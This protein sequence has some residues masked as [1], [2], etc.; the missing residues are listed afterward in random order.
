MMFKSTACVADSCIFFLGSLFRMFWSVAV[1][2]GNARAPAPA[3]PAFPFRAALCI[4]R[5]PMDP[6]FAKRRSCKEEEGGT[7]Q[8]SQWTGSVPLMTKQDA[9]N[10]SNS[11]R[12]SVPLS[13]QPAL[14]ILMQCG[15]R[16]LTFSL[17]SLFP[18]WC[19]E[20]GQAAL[21]VPVWMLAP[22]CNAWSIPAP[23]KIF[24][25]TNSV[26][27]LLT[28]LVMDLEKSP[29]SCTEQICVSSKPL[30]P[31]CQEAQLPVRIY[32]ATDRS[33]VVVGPNT[34]LQTLCV[35][36]IKAKACLVSQNKSRANLFW[37]KKH[38]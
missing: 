27:H 4:P 12:T 14:R 15:G 32:C 26:S 25:C 24:F 30:A 7:Q 28:C 1:E 2:L 36:V 16:C 31:S 22:R 34:P 33:R 37:N 38:A 20:K 10:I 6:S 3:A 29:G 18:G 35:R 13:A 11:K 8:P 19:L 9:V 21:A 23:Y 17:M 5:A